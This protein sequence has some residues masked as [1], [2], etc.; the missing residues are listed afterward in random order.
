M[1]MPTDKTMAWD[2]FVVKAIFLSEF[3]ALGLELRS[4]YI[5]FDMRLFITNRWIYGHYTDGII[6]MPSWW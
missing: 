2:V 1:S 5:G 4:H 3:Q 6:G